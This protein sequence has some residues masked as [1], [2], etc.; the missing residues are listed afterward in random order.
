M[1]SAVI[2]AAG[3][4][5]WEVGA[6]FD[7]EHPL[8]SAEGR[9]ALSGAV[10]VV[11]FSSPD[12]FEDHVRCC[13][14]WGVPLVTGTT[15]LSDRVD[16]VR[17]YVDR[18][19]GTVF[20]SPNFS[21]G[22]AI[23]RRAMRTTL[24]LAA[25]LEDFDVSVHEVHHAA[26]QDRP[27]G[28][29]SLLAGDIR[30]ALPWKYAVSDELSTVL[31]LPEGPDVSSSRVGSVFGEHTVRIEAPDDQIVLHHAARSRRG[32]AGGA[33]HAARWLLGRTGF[34]TM[35]DMIDDWIGVSMQPS[36]NH[37]GA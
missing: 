3:M 1:G 24:A 18:C 27:S 15:G 16:S 21:V 7:R 17:S 2:E 6:C 19:G 22:V 33:L 8:N 20:Y 34:F 26:K 12:V 35:D 36:T 30:R 5:G 4:I 10:A 32:F 37:I 13:V 23:L 28:T 31:D 9:G 14:A 29:A 11:D 25:H